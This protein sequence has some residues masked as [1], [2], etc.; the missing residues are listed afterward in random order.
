MSARTAVSLEGLLA[1]VVVSLEVILP[2]SITKGG[3][4]YRNLRV[5][6]RANFRR[7]I[8]HKPWDTRAATMHLHKATF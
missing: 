2:T 6:I 4:E 5:S 8:P 7:A 1:K 3:P